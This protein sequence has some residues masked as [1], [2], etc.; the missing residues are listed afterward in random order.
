[1]NKGVEIR[2]RKF[3]IGCERIMN[4]IVSVDA[5]WGIGVNNDLLFHVPEDMQ[6]FKS[7]TIGKTVV[8][9]EK[10]FYSLPGQKP[11]KDR[12]NIVLSDNPELKIEGVTICNSLSELLALLKTHKTEDVFIIGGQAV[13]ELMLPYCSV[14]YVTQF[15]TKTP[16]D[17]HF[18]NL[19]INSEW[20]LVERSAKLVSKGLTF[21]FDRYEKV[22]SLGGISI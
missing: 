6:Y 18:P 5:D 8:M 17:K 4:L 11:L 20:R 22:K 1:M 21:T 10:T 15:Y 2:L 19:A 13:Y 7:M 14:T 16:A 9:G 3:E 12:N